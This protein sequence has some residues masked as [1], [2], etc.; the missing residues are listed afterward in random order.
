MSSI[1]SKYQALKDAIIE[2][3]P[4]GADAPVVF[5]SIEVNEKGFKALL[6]RNLKSRP[7][8]S[9]LVL[10]CIIALFI[11]A[12][13]TAAT[14][15]IGA[16]AAPSYAAFI[17]VFI[18][19]ITHRSALISATGDGFD[20][21]FIESKTGSRFVVYDKFSLPF[22]KITNVKV[23]TGRF[24]AALTFEFLHEGKEYKIRNSVPNKKRKMNEQA[25]NLKILLEEVS[26]KANERSFR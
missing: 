22:D 9:P 20:F 6:G 16:V 2:F 5:S 24:N 7:I 10:A 23:S 17:P 1:S 18:V 26:H 21:Y 13:S 15:M 3:S 19:Y 11:F 12:A 8:S 14:V 4:G 25:E